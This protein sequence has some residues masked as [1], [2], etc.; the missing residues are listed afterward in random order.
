MQNIMIKKRSGDLKPLDITQIQSKAAKAVKGIK[1]ARQDELEIKAQLQ[2]FSGMTSK[3]I[4]QSLIKAAVDLISV[5][6]PF[7]TFVAARLMSEDMYH[8]VGK[9]YEGKKGNPYSHSLEQYLT[10]GVDQGRINSSF[11]RKYDLE[12]LNNYIDGERDLLFNYIGLQTFYDRY[13][14]KD[15]S[16]DLFELPQHMF[17]AIA[18]FLSQNEKDFMKSTKEIYDMISK[19]EVMLATPTLSNARTNRNQL[20]SC[21]ANSVA[22]TIEGIFD[23]YKD[24]AL[25]SKFGGGIG[26]DWA[27]VRASNGSIDD[28][29]NAAG[30][31]IPFLKITNDVAIAVDQLGVR[32]GSI[33]IYIEPWHLDIADFVDL[34]K[35]SGEERRRA[36]D[37]FP[38]IWMNDLFMERAE[39][40]LPW[41]LFDPYETPDLHELYGNEFK[42]KYEEYE[43]RTDLRTETISAKD[44]WKKML[45]SYFETGMPFLAFKDEANRRNPNK[46][47]GVIRSSNLCQEIF[48]VTSPNHY[49]VLLELENGTSICVE[50]HDD[51]VVLI[52]G[53]E[54]VKLGKKVSNIDTLI[55]DG[56]E[57]GIDFISKIITKPGRT[58]V[59]NLASVNLSRI[60]SDE[61]LARIIPIAIRALD[62]VVD[63]NLYPISQASRTNKLSRSIGLGVMGE[64]QMIAEKGLVWGTQEHF[65]LVDEVMENVHYH[66]IKASSLLGKEKGSYPE[67]EGSEW[68]KGIITYDTANKDA[69]A[70]TSRTPNEERLAELRVL[71]SQW[72]RNGYIMAVAPTGT[73][74]IVVGTTQ[75]IEPIYKKIWSEE[76]LSGLIKVTAPNLSLDNWAG[77]VPAYDVDQLMLI[78]A[79]AV[80]QK[81]IDQGQSLNVFLDPAKASGKVMNAIYMLAWKLGIKS[82]YYLRSQSPSS[83]EDEPDINDRSIECKD[84]Q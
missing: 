55:I 84:C 63:L 10:Y 41:T 7:W 29:E 8:S 19:F 46:H 56:K 30:G 48:Q 34:K 81:W 36:H 26:T 64:A 79:G 23:A 44:L 53:K 52:N 15:L 27:N 2:F 69:I 70:L 59:C 18:M 11:W 74:S 32:K 35:N 72:M 14:L 6:E 42:A 54:A 38:S 62:N 24:Y 25:L 83:K 65:E 33:A 58:L 57:E 67:F 61:D 37:L 45:T 82:T 68:N 17:M 47:T 39:L 75:T 40:D 22:D 4:Q 78:K 16:G 31:I 28:H 71:V 20:S 50:E 5:E 21:Y 43:A 3:D 76:N 80:R 13:L 1:G 49:G 73:I 51:V 60:N 77:Y 66:A 12:E 9:L